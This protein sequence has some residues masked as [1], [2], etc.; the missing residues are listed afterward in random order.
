MDEPL[1]DGAAVKKKLK[2]MYLKNPWHLDLN[3]PRDRLLHA[4]LHAGPAGSDIERELK[5]VEE[6]LL[7]E[8]EGVMRQVFQDHPNSSTVDAGMVNAAM[9][10]R[11]LAEE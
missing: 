1:I 7:S 2:K 6:K 9:R 3:L 4:L 10:K 5:V 11:A 8:L